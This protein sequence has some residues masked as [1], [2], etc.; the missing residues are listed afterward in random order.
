M[1]RRDALKKLAAGGALVVTSPVILPSVRVAHAAS[2]AGTGMNGLP[3][4]GEPVPFVDVPATGGRFDRRQVGIVIDNS[5]VECE[6]G[7]LPLVSYEWRIVSTS[8]QHDKKTYQLRLAEATSSVA[9][10]AGTELA[11]TPPSA[12]GFSGPTA[13]SAPSWAGAFVVRKR[14]KL[15]DETLKNGDSYAVETRIRWQCD[16]SRSAVEAE[17]LF[18]GQGDATPSVTNTSWAIVDA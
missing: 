9:D 11:S 1:D 6:D 8:W 18:T 16:R 2:P 17:Y 3:A 10:P 12:S 5:G 7:S 15:G 14:G 4:P 13:Y